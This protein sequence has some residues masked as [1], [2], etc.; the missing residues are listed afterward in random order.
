MR[1][2]LGHIARVGKR[3][4]APQRFD[5]VRPHAGLRLLPAMRP[6]HAIAFSTLCLAACAKND[7]AK[8]T[9][10]ALPGFSLELPSGVEKLA[11]LDYTAGKLRLDQLSGSAGSFIIYWSFGQVVDSAS[12]LEAG[13]AAARSE[14]LDP[15]YVE[16]LEKGAVT[17]VAI[18]REH[19][20]LQSY[21]QCGARVLSI[22]TAGVGVPMHNKIVGSLRCEPDPAREQAA[23][24]MPLAIDLPGF[25][26]YARDPGELG[27]TSSTATVMIRRYASSSLTVAD[28]E[29]ESA[30]LFQAMKL[31][32][33]AQPRRGNVLPFTA[34]IDGTAELGVLRPIDCPD[35]KL[36]VIAIAPD[37]ASLHD[38][39]QRVEAARCLAPGESPPTWPDQLPPT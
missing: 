6:L 9:R 17:T 18:D 8:V 14:E 38:V 36:L 7:R 12:A 11:Q 28:F 30:A 23:T 1:S 22:A 16:V 26:A 34:N 4:Y 39:E 3:R 27:L 31:D 21:V 13:K 10:R 19:A 20:R 37:D 2:T 33:K 35:F 5:F 15:T 24:T 29:R 25:S 32:A